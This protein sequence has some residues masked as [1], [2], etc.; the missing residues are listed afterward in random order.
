MCEALS[1]VPVL[2]PA[3]LSADC[4]LHYPWPLCGHHSLSK[5]NVGLELTRAQNTCTAAGLHI[6]SQA[7]LHLSDAW[8]ETLKHISL[9]CPSAASASDL[10]LS[11]QLTHLCSGC[12]NKL[13]L[14]EI[15]VI[16]S[17][18]KVSVI[19][20]CW[21]YPYLWAPLKINVHKFT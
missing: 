2:P 12:R 14:K 6:Q 9:T 7:E 16:L 5:T 15:P 19:S 8:E 3:L 13:T 10:R 4:S 17:V 1:N 18:L 20:T 21:E 11:F